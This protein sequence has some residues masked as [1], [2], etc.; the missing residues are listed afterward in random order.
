MYR[1][2]PL[3][4]DARSS[5]V[6]FTVSL[7]LIVS[8]SLVAV[9]KGSREAVFKAELAKESEES[10]FLGAIPTVPSKRINDQYEYR[11]HNQRRTKQAPASIPSPRCAGYRLMCATVGP[12]RRMTIRVIG[13]RKK[14]QIDFQSLETAFEHH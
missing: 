4:I 10:F 8:C 1:P 9:V 5:S 13:P 3:P 2:G 11:L 14:P 7:S 6:E 12:R